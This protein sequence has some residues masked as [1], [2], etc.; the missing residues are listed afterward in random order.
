SPS[1]RWTRSGA[2]SSGNPVSAVPS[3]VAHVSSIF[4]TSISGNSS[5]VVACEGSG[6][7]TRTFA[8]LWYISLS[9][10]CQL[11]EKRC[12][13]AGTSLARLNSKSWLGPE[14]LGQAPTQDFMTFHVLPPSME[15]EAWQEPP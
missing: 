2:P 4:A 11:H 3:G 15:M 1:P 7:A 5:S 10:L 6:F 13:P 8:Q 14:R 9:L 12:T